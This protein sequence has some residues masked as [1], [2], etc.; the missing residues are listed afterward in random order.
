MAAEK[1]STDLNP[2]LRQPSGARGKPICLNT[3]Y[4]PIKT[5]AEVNL[6]QYEVSI[7][8]DTRSDI[9]IGKKQNMKIFEKMKKRNRDVFSSNPMAFDGFKKAYSV[10]V[11]PYL[12]D[13]KTKTFKVNHELE[14][15]D[16]DP[17]SFTV[18]ICLNMTKRLRELMESL[19]CTDM[20]KNI[21]VTI[22]RMLD[23]MLRYR[24]LLKYETVGK[25]RYFLFN[26]EINRPIDIGPA[27]Q[28]VTGFFSSMKAS[29]HGKGSIMIN[30]DLAH[31]AFYKEQ[32]LLDFIKNV[33]H[34]ER[35]DL[36]A[37]LDIE[38]RKRLKC[39][40]ADLRVETTHT[41]RTYRIIGLG[42]YGSNRQMF[43]WNNSE[44]GKIVQR[45][46]QDYFEKEYKKPIKYP[47]LI[48]IQ[49]FP[50]EK[51][52]YLP[53]E[54]CVVARGQRS[55]GN[56]SNREAG[57]F[58]RSS[59][60]PPGERLEQIKSIY[61]DNEFAND[62]MI[63]SLKFEMA[64][65]PFTVTGRILSPPKLRM[66]QEVQPKT[67]EWDTRGE[68]F[69][70]GAVVNTWAVINYTNTWEGALERYIRNL[71][72]LGNRKGMVFKSPVRVTKGI[73]ENV[74][75]QFQNLK[76]KFPEIQMILVVLKEADSLYSR[77]KTVGD[78]EIS[79]ITQCVKQRCMEEC[80][81]VTIGNLLFKI[82]AK[83]GGINYIWS[84]KSKLM[85]KR[86]M[87]MGADVNHPS[88]GDARTPSMAAVV[89]SIDKDV[90]K[91]AVEV[92]PQ[93]HRNEIIQD[94]K[95]ITKNLLKS[96]CVAA[97]NRKPQHIIVYRDGV[98]N[99][100]FN[101]VLQHEFLAIREACKEL[102][103][104]YTPAITFLV[105][106]KRHHTRFFPVDEIG[107][108]IPPGTV[109]DS[110]I[111]HP[112]ERDFYLCSHHGIKGTSRPT[113]Y[114]VLWD[115]NNLTMDQLQEFT[116]NMCHVYSRCSKSVSLPA[117]V[118]YAHLAAFRAKVHATEVNIQE[119][120]LKHIKMN[121]EKELSNK[122][123]YI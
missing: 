86:L 92:R 12:K 21:Q 56:L 34:V 37:P 14:E 118:A 46:V 66:G 96:F 119:S 80:R 32:P 114:H 121:R 72:S 6:A 29:A 19:K 110:G 48:C 58:I 45:T 16:G 44:S 93:K 89:A 54:Y 40:L 4:F 103:E 57:N 10:E 20:H 52:I 22:F 87:V 51:N 55:V 63:A 3:N 35:N 78:L 82:N 115:D 84:R 101:Q 123:Y 88:A 90:S 100:Q 24:R 76:K 23:T 117:P 107:K 104:T 1:E 105:V 25:K 61:N 62:E 13:K 68:K 2:P 122:L 28:G 27:V 7:K 113:H 94:F 60:I 30:I 5:K 83:M 9:K 49:A 18:Q 43:P 69:Y 8:Q 77:I 79:V 36:V 75:Q 33:L 47:R 50:K 74:T 81:F 99:S 15:G 67:G 98:S 120:E 17:V 73:R 42:M 116:Y 108:N 85:E 109:V 71:R 102:G 106:M 91:Y 39:G 95:E 31:S 97:N 11:L 65:S 26:R 41:P 111:T 38:L 112:I 59:A 64:K 70:I 53:L